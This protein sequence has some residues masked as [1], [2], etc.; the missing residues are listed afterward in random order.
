MKTQLILNLYDL[1]YSEERIDRKN[2]CTVNAI[3][4]RTF[5]RYIKEINVFLMHYKRKY[6]LKVDE[7]SG[8]YYIEKI[9]D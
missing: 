6:V 5:Y 4:E 8:I 7:P 2:F 1:L 9:K 3:S